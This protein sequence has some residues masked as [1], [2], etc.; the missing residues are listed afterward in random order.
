MSNIRKLTVTGLVLM[1]CGNAN[2]DQ[3]LGLTV[4]DAYGKVDNSPEIKDE[5]GVLVPYVAYGQR[6]YP[7]RSFKSPAGSYKIPAGGYS[8]YIGE[9]EGVKRAYLK[10][11][12]GASATWYLC[13]KVPSFSGVDALNGNGST[14]KGYIPYTKTTEVVKADR[15]GGKYDYMYSEQNAKETASIFEVS[16]KTG[17]FK[18]STSYMKL[19]HGRGLSTE[20]RNYWVGDNLVMQEIKQVNNDY[21]LYDTRAFC[22][23]PT[24][25]TGAK[26][27]GVTVAPVEYSVWAEVNYAFDRG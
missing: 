27:Q 7:S 18:P 26:P 25:E 13:S 15:R 8:M 9:K 5:A 20:V 3:L 4:Y 24:Q 12:V 14:V 22:A 2:A 10:S 16:G 11:G 23:K 17:T 19:M 1:V 21:G 6:V